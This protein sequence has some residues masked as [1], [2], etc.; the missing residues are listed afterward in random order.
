MGPD[1]QRISPALKVGGGASA[2][3]F[4]D[5]AANATYVGIQHPRAGR[6]SVVQASGS[7]IPI[8]GLESSIGEPPPKVRATLAGTGFSRT[9]S[10]HATVPD[11]VTVSFAEQTGTLLHVVGRVQ[12]TSGTI[13]FRPAFGPAGRRQL[14]A[15]ISNNGVPIKTENLGSFV[16]P[17]PPRPGRAT[18]LHV[19]AGGRTF[20]FSFTP[21]PN[22]A[23]TLLR[24]VA[25]DGRHLQRLLP[26]ATRR[27]TV[28]V[29][30]FRD[31][32]TVTVT[33]LGAD[34]SRGPAV[35]AS[36]RRKT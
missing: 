9:L 11:N 36:A 25:T 24:I 7:D 8:T 32:V 2:I 21:P 16:V 6:W 3:A 19:Q 17:R 13:H 30:G 20:T 15:L 31:G 4:A 35:S 26:P 27:G 18:R 34:G 29:I 22:A 5:A 12:G 33:G 28:P 1:G 23:H 10:Y 14:I